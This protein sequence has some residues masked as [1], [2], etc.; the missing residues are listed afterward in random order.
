MGK[1]TPFPGSFTAGERL[2]SNP[3]DVA[4]SFNSFFTNIGSSLANKI[5]STDVHF[6]KYLH[7]PNSSSFFLTPTSPLEIIRIGKELKPSASCGFDGISSTLIKHALPFIAFLLAHIFNLSF[8]TGSVPLNLK[9]AKVIPIFKSG[10]V[11][12]IGNYRPIS[13]LP[14]FSKILERLVYNR[15]FKFASDFHLLYDNQYGFRSKHST[16]MALT[17]FIDNVT[18]ALC[19]KLYA[20]DVNCCLL[21]R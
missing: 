10:D 16:D 21:E 5:P 17:Q 6:S 2:L 19:K 8:S 12:T 7:N 11:H 13:I 18:D 1:K 15:L 20:T 14:C 3:T 9:V 4:N